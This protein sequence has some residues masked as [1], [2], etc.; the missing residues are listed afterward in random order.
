MELEQALAKIKELESTN[1]DLVTRVGTLETNNNDLVMQR[2]QLKAKIKEGTGDET[3][4]AELD[5]YKEQLASVEA[6]KEAIKGEFTSKLSK[7]QMMQ[8]LKESGVQA[9]NDDAMNA[10]VDLV[11]QRA[12]YDDGAFKFVKEDGTTR[13]TDG[14]KPYGV[15]DA[16]NELKESEKAYLF[17][18]QTGGG[19]TETPA[20]PNS[21]PDINSIIDA[22]LKY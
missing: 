12:V 3:L 1:A 2:E 9:Q 4:K 19:M 16:V 15:I 8:T 22:G 21:K 17:K 20:V 14:D 11:A 6:D 10:I 7:L 18:A 5:N 13:F